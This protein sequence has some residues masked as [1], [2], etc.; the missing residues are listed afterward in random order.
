MGFPQLKSIESKQL[1][2]DVL[3]T[4]VRAMFNELACMSIALQGLQDL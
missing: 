3:M 2:D 1:H 4:I